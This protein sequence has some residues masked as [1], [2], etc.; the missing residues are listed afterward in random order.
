MS[1]FSMARVRRLTPRI[2]RLSEKHGKRLD[3]S[4]IKR[5][6]NLGIPPVKWLPDGVAGDAL[7]LVEQYERHLTLPEIDPKTKK[8][9]RVFVP[10]AASTVLHML[11]K[12]PESV[13]VETRADAEAALALVV[14]FAQE[15][16]GGNAVFAARM[17]R[18]EKSLNNADVFM[19]PRYAKELVGGDK[20]S[21]SLSK[22]LKMNAVKHNYDVTGRDSL[23][24]QG[25]ALQD[26]FARWLREKGFEAVR[27][28]PKE[29]KGDDWVEPEIAGARI[30]RDEAEKARQEARESEERAAKALRAV[31]ARENAVSAREAAV[32]ERETA[33]KDVEA[34]E[35]AVGERETAMKDVEKRERAVKTREDLV[36]ALASTQKTTRLEQIAR[37]S[38]LDERARQIKTDQ[39]VLQG[40][41]EDLDRILQ[42]IR[43]MAKQWNEAIGLR[44]Q[45]I[46]V[47]LA[48]KGEIAAEVAESPEVGVLAALMDRLTGKNRE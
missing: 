20:E 25:K 19:A 10:K 5:A 43:D 16:F 24:N 44:G 12:L 29:T 33:M 34:R 37:S 4:S 14:D 18:D 21:V 48:R 41:A 38:R 28:N 11:V 35:L 45:G 17:D 46:R 6:I 31:E 13:P 47:T 3:K 42:P 7:D 39:T 2:L 9:K 26:E 27:G 36:Q 23:A 15:T 22:H 1:T 40:I 30:D 32:R 8:P